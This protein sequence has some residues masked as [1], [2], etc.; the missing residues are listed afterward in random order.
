MIG[1]DDRDVVVVLNGGQGRT[2]QTM[3]DALAAVWEALTKHGGQ[4]TD[5]T[6]PL[7]A[8]A[9]SALTQ[10]EFAA[11]LLPAKGYR[12]EKETVV[13]NNR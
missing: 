9:L 7:H 6:R 12:V 3:R 1:E 10:V 2:R 5:C 4:R 8:N 13:Q 11:I